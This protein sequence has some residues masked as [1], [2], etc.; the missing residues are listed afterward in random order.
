MGIP[1]FTFEDLEELNKK[2]VTEEETTTE[3]NQEDKTNG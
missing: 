3:E 1:S 2:K